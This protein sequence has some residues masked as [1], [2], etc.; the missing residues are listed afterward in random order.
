MRDRIRGG[1]L[2]EGEGRKVGVRVG[3]LDLGIVEVRV[4]CVGLARR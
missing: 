4:S 1:S 3:S 2:V